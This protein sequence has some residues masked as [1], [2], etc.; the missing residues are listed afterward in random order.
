MEH[1]DP[2]SPGRRAGTGSSVKAQIPGLPPPWILYRKASP[3]PAC[4]SVLFSQVSQ[5]FT[6][7]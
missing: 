4:G 1:R 7:A 2:V 3:P 6:N 5:Q